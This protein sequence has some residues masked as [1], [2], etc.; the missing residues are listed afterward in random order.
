MPYTIH[1]AAAHIRDN[2]GHMR[3]IDVFSDS[4]ESTKEEALAEIEN[5]KTEVLEAIGIDNT[6]GARKNALDA[7]Q[8]ALD[9]AKESITAE[10]KRIEKIKN[11]QATLDTETANMIVEYFD[12]NKNYP[13]GA[14][15]RQTS[16]QGSGTNATSSVKLFKFITNHVAGG[17][18]GT[19]AIQIKLSEEVFDLKS[20]LQLGFAER[21]ETV[22]PTSGGINPNN[23]LATTSTSAC[24]TNAIP[25][26]GNRI[27]TIGNDGYVFQV[28]LYQTDTMIGGT[29]GNPTHGERAPGN[30]LVSVPYNSEA[31]YFRME[32]R[33]TDGA[34]LTTDT[35]DPTSDYSIILAALK[36]YVVG[37]DIKINK[38]SASPDGTN[39]QILQTN[40]DGTTTWINNDAP[41]AV[42]KLESLNPDRVRTLLEYDI[43]RITLPNWGYYNLD[44]SGDLQD[45][46]KQKTRIATINYYK[47]PYAITIRNGNQSGNFILC[48][49]HDDKTLDTRTTNLKAAEI[50]ANTLFRICYNKGSTVITDIETYTKNIYYASKVSE[51]MN[52]IPQLLQCFHKYTGIG[53]SLMAGYTK[54]ENTTVNSA[55]ARAAKNNWFDFLM[56]KISRDGTNLAVGS[57]ST[58]S[59]R[60]ADD[61]LGADINDADIDTDC[62]FV[63][64][65]VNDINQSATLGSQADINTSDITQCADSTYGNLY[66]I[67]AKLHEFNPYA[68][69]FVFTIPVL[70]T[71]N[72]ADVNAAIEYCCSIADN[73][74]CVHLDKD[75]FTVPFLTANNT[76]GH[77]N[78]IAYAYISGIIE[79]AVSNYIYE[80]YTDFVWIPYEH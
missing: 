73:A 1:T 68:K 10:G 43:G 37:S 52:A 11:N 80:N 45:Y 8:T 29:A 36:V 21:S 33:R 72:V 74:Y 77:Y 7:I 66:Y 40:G 38:P 62:Y 76:N 57:S 42:E 70:G 2:L 35:T 30:S 71:K 41:E 55:T 20:A 23:G 4:V 58:H 65:G 3:N 54:I 9:Q 12:E 64:L 26:N 67:L 14:Y 32:F 39:G 25:I 50:P 51:R 63:G 6:E 44:A 16:T 24:R 48:T 59:W 75:R 5:K 47:S 19:D 27:V 17:W 13:A 18:I 22:T 79:D 28:W 56:N 31:N 61:S 49:Y 69:I 53:D 46:S 60:Y 15:V 78:P 34:V